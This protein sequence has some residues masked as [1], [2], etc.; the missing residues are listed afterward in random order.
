MIRRIIPHE[1]TKSVIISSVF[2]LVL[3]FL[4]GRVIFQSRISKLIALKQQRQRTELENK[5][6]KKLEELKKIREKLEP[7]KESA[8][9]LGEIAKFAGQL[10]MKLIT[11]SAV[12]IQRFD[13]YV[14]LSVKLSL[15]TS[16]HEVGNFIA[17]L[18]TA[19]RFINI[20]NLD[21]M[22]NKDSEKT[23]TQVEA[24][25]VVSTL[26]LTDTSLEI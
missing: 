12:P 1:I 5:V 13:E 16:Y 26:Y 11:I 17:E 6:A 18:E 3:F 7:L 15:D 14:K 23:T 9:F 21:I 8:V 2:F 22:P 20:E 24:T 25:L 19:K 10:N 4:G